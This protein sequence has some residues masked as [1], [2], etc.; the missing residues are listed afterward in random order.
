[1]SCSCDDVLNCDSSCKCYVP[2]YTTDPNYTGISI[3]VAVL[4]QK[5]NTIKEEDAHLIEL[6]PTYLSY[7]SFQAMFFNKC[8]K[9]V[10]L[11]NVQGY[12]WQQYVSNLKRNIIYS[13]L[14]SEQEIAS[15]A[16]PWASY[17]P[18]VSSVLDTC[19]NL[20][21]VI[22]DGYETDLN[23]P[24]EC[25]DACSVLEFTRT[26]ANIKYLTDI[27]NECNVKCAITLD[28]FFDNLA[29]QGLEI[30]ASNGLPLDASGNNVV[31]TGLVNALITANFRSCTPGVKDIKIKWPFLINFNSVTPHTADGSNNMVDGIPEPSGNVWPNINFYTDA[32]GSYNPLTDYRS[33][34]LKYDTVDT[35]GVAYVSDSCGNKI[36]V[37]IPAYSRYS[38]YL[39]STIIVRK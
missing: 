20:L 28:E 17:D 11:D 26:L 32:D 37:H 2:I 33:P 16:F 21:K 29:A 4:E 24:S 12:A 7:A 30:D 25:W 36:P 39:Y 19:F 6:S 31:Y 3:N 14:N 35:S 9:F 18:N 5:I 8:N 27:G 23:I 38:A 13:S 10:S 1:M 22:T 34:E 15:A